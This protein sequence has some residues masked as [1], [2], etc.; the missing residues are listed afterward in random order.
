MKGATYPSIA[1]SLLLASS[2]RPA[3]SQQVFVLDKFLQ[4]NVRLTAGQI[5]SVHRGKAVATVLDS[6]TPDEVFVF[7]TVH[8]DAT[9]ESYLKF[10]NDFDALR[11]LPSYLAV[12]KFSNPPQPSD[13]GGFTIDPEDFKELKSCQPG[14]CEVQLPS[15]A[16]PVA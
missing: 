16:I 10:A 13:L 14:D 9:P 1:L 2:L 11:K 6:P 7:G 5:D 4:E 3:V 8:V 15:E 12:Q